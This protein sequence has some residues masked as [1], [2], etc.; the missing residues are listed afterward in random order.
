MNLLRACSRNRQPAALADN[1]TVNADTRDTTL[2]VLANDTDPDG[3]PLTLISIGERT[4][5]GTVT[6]NAGALLYT[7]A[8]GFVGTETFNYTIQD[9]AG[10]PATALVTVTVTSNPAPTVPDPKPTAPDPKKGSGSFG[11]LDWLIFAA[12]FWLGQQAKPHRQ[13]DKTE[14]RRDSHCRRVQTSVK[15]VAVANNHT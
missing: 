5:G 6:I 15:T 12:C 8:P 11:W 2:N 9:S 1:Y 14:H 13:R 3:N 7:P 10:L 4:N